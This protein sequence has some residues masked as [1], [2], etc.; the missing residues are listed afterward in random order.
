MVEKGTIGKKY[1]LGRAT[2]DKKNV[3]VV[4]NDDEHVFD[5]KTRAT[6]TLDRIRLKLGKVAKGKIPIAFRFC[7]CD[8]IPVEFCNESTTRIRSCFMGDATIIHIYTAKGMKKRKPTAFA[9]FSDRLSKISED[10]ESVVRSCLRLLET[11]DGQTK[12]PLDALPS[13][14][15][16]CAL[17]FRDLGRATLEATPKAKIR[18]QSIENDVNEIERHLKTLIRRPKFVALMTYR[19]DLHSISECV[20]NIQKELLHAKI[21]DDHPVFFVKTD[22][23]APEIDSLLTVLGR[24]SFMDLCG[25]KHAGTRRRIADLLSMSEIDVVESIKNKGVS[26]IFERGMFRNATKPMVKASS[27]TSLTDSRMP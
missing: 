22:K 5:F 10:A 23:P 12:A 14:L 8:G 3:T 4:L 15:P 27:Y 2:A 21:N 6:D 24:V 13:P 16:S 1:S 9:E 11:F 17:F 18:W 7:Y 19:A 25:E 20:K 26:T